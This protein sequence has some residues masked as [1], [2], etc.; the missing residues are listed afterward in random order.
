MASDSDIDTWHYNA[1][2]HTQGLDMWHFY[3]FSK[4]FKKIKKLKKI[5]KN[6]D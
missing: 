5:K 3:F 1:T 6:T 2:W 4:N